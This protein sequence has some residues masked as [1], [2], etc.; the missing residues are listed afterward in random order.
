MSGNIQQKSLAGKNTSNGTRGRLIVIEGTDGSG[1]SVQTRILEERLKRQEHRVQITDFPQYGNSFFADMIEKY[2]RGEFGWPQEL[3]DHLKIYPLPKKRRRDSKQ[4]ADEYPDKGSH[5]N[6]SGNES[7]ID[8]K[9]TL[10]G[11][12]VSS[13]DEVNPYLSSLLYA[14]DRWMLK[15]QMTKWLDEG[16]IITS[17]RYVCSNMAHQGAKIEDAGEQNRFFKWIEELEYKVFAIPKPDL[18]IYLSVPIEISQK[19]MKE[20]LQSSE[21]DKSEFDIHEKDREYLHAVQMIYKKL[22]EMDKSWVTVTCTKNG[23]ILPIEEIAETIWS[24]VN[25]RLF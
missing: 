2:L 22:A 17:N 10:S 6:Q 8:E 20:R 25:K 18:N 21:D 7:D 13:P 11:S 3:R 19:L 12:V 24:V 5:K 1:K 9:D 15:D 14:G 23:Q 4:F 16:I